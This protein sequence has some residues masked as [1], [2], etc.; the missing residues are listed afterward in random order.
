[1]KRALS[2]FSSFLIAFSGLSIPANATN[3]GE[4]LKVS[5]S[6]IGIS[7][8]EDVSFN[9]SNRYSVIDSGEE[10]Y[11]NVLRVFCDTG[12]NSSWL[13]CFATN[14]N[15]TYNINGSNV[16]LF[17]EPLEQNKN[18]ILNFD[19]KYIKGDY[20]NTNNF[21]FAPQVDDFKHGTNDHRNKIPFNY[22]WTHYQKVFN[23]G[24]ATNINV[25]FNTLGST[26]TVYIDN[27][28]VHEAANV[29]YS[30]VSGIYPKVEYG[31]ITSDNN[32]TPVGERLVL[33]HPDGAEI[34][35]V[36]VGGIPVECIGGKYTVEEVSGD[37]VITTAITS[38]SIATQVTKNFYTDGTDIYVPYGITASAF[39]EENK[40]STVSVANIYNNG[41]TPECDELITI[42][43]AFKIEVPSE[44]VKTF[45]FKY[46]C[47]FDKNNKI[48]VT[49]LTETLDKVINKSDKI[50][51]FDYSRDGVLTVTDVVQLRNVVLKD[52][53]VQIDTV[54]LNVQKSKIADNQVTYGIT[55][56]MLEEGIANVGNRAM[57]ANV[58]KRAINGETITIVTLGGSITQGAGASDFS[59]P[60][61]AKKSQSELCYASLVRDWFQYMFPGKVKFVNAGISGTSSIFGNDRLSTD[62]L[63]YNPDF[64]I[65]E[66]AVND[67][68]GI[69]TCY[70]HEALIRR[71]LENDCAVLQLFNTSVA[72]QFAYC[73]QEVQG[74]VG[75]YYD[76]PQISTRDALLGKT[77]TTPEGNSTFENILADGTHPNDRGYAMYATLI[78]NLLNKTYENLNS[79]TFKETTIPK[80]YYHKQSEL[81]HDVKL[82]D[83]KTVG[84][85]D[86]KV[87]V[88]SLGGFTS[89]T[90]S[91]NF[92]SELSQMY[93]VSCTPNVTSPL[94][95]KIKDCHTASIL[96]ETRTTGFFVKV[97]V[98][99]IT[100]S[101]LLYTDDNDGDLQNKHGDGAVRTV[102]PS[103]YNADGKDVLIKIYP[104]Q[105]KNTSVT[106]GALCIIRQLGIS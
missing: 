81:L 26:E 70:S 55:D 57:L 4:L 74:P 13:D 93:G 92:N 101:T 77:Y 106:S 62:V 61:G 96:F 91:T 79:I 66:F 58:M 16:L 84:V 50:S 35:S 23:S 72:Q 40:L 28:L 82:Y 18:Y 22:E 10:G 27:Y 56:Q 29:T 94:M 63:K 49:D 98:W 99:D 46:I 17:N 73:G 88:V 65:V 44:E 7:G 87:E 85:I 14:I 59:M 83:P 102:T 71:A 39:M 30:G 11:N 20:V 38:N 105:A 90:S 12:A 33:A 97:E 51:L 54:K 52:M 32:Y 68:T 21:S 75:K 95:L 5:K 103:Y 89:N 1:M 104:N 25:K 69:E 6:P 24:T 60:A 67:W 31:Y 78:N 36:T 2:I 100:G 34:T 45:N 86:D 9:R 80:E 42:D 76:V 43:S 19:Y 41:I 37:V 15:K 64:L 53:N 48:T 47:D 3:L 8:F